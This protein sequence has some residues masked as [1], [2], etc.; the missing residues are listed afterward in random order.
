MTLIWTNVVAVDEVAFWS[1]F[2]HFKY[3]LFDHFMV[4]SLFECIFYSVLLLVI[5]K[6][7]FF[8]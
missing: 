2:F 1:Y 3:F 7:D 6:N 4:D 5:L 8:F